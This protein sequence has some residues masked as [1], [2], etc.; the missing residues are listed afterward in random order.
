MAL[1]A[2]EGGRIVRL[3]DVGDRE[4]EALYRHAW[5]TVYPSLGEGYGM[6]VAEALSR[7]KVCLA[8]QAGA[9][10]EAGAGL[11]D[12]I[13]PS[14]PA[15]IAAR[16]GEYLADPDRVA[17]REAEI[18]ALYRPTSWSQTAHAVRSMIEATIKTA[19][20]SASRD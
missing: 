5:L 6:P 11:S 18:R 7:G 9:V 19:D 4:L 2:A 15:S 10:G 8:S 1:E 3:S 13:D 14:D 16:V 12:A 20:M 17:A